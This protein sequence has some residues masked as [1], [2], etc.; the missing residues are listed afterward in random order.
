[1]AEEDGEIFEKKNIY[2][3]KGIFLMYIGQFE[4]ALEEFQ[5]VLEIIHST[6]NDKLTS[7]EALSSEEENCEILYNIGLCHL[8]VTFI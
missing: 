3:F 5:E 8:H 7:D 6:E 1:M 4:L 2:W